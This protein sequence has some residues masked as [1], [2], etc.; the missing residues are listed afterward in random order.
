[1]SEEHREHRAASSSD[2]QSKT[3]SQRTARPTVKRWLKRAALIVLAIVLLPYLYYRTTSSWRQLILTEIPSVSD[4]AAVESSTPDSV[5]ED[6]ASIRVAAWNIA[7]GRGSGDSNWK[8]GGDEKRGRVKQIAAMIKTFDADVVVLNEVD[9]SATWSGGFDQADLIAREAGYS[10]Y[11]K[12]TNLDFGFL[13]GRW[14]FGNAILSRLPI[15]EPEVVNLTP[16]AQ[17]ESW[18]VGHKR[19]LGCTDRVTKRP[20]SFSGWFAS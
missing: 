15:S 20:E 1:M 4:V 5:E 19:S 9:F 18:L 3:S 17:W 14:Y 8:E 10:V 6:Q 7:H 11:L 13:V 12:Q 16:L 2:L